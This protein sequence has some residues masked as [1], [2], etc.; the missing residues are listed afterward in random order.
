[1]TISQSVWV[2]LVVN[3][4]YPTDLTDSQ[5]NHIKDFF[6]LPKPTGRPREVD[7]RQIVNAILYLLFTGCQWRFIPGII[8]VGE[9]FMIIFGNGKRMALGFVFTKLYALKNE[10]GKA[11]TNIRQPGQPIRKASKRQLCRLR[12]DLMQE[13]RLMDV[14]GTF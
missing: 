7:F 12:A 9:Q 13:R 1:M 4:I 11:K 5:W 2:N 10:F 8:R 6:P 14:N 3:K